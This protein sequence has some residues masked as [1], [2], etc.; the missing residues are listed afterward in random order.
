MRQPRPITTGLLRDWE[1]PRS[2]GSKESQGRVLV[3]GGNV[4]M[5]GGVLLAAEAAMRAGAGKLQVATVEQVAVPMAMQVPEAYVAGLPADADGNLAPE[6]AAEIVELAADCS[7]VLLGPGIMSPDSAV[8]LLS[9]VVPQLAVPVVVDALGMAYLTEHRDGVAHLDGRAILSPNLGE[10]A[11][12][13]G[14]D[15]DEV[16]DD[17]LTHARRLATDARAVVVTGAATTV[18][19]TPDDAACWQDE[20]GGEG[21]AVSGSGDVKAGVLLGLLGR[22]ATPEQAA[23]WGAFVHGRAGERLVAVHGRRGYLARELLVEIPR[24]LAELD[25]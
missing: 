25:G 2:G 3:V 9:E 4:R 22:G 5:P 24:T 1:L 20:S 17:P 11:V 19:C 23:A 7:A 14:L 16:S 12:T 8:A 18:I 6:S 10:L 21:M 15:Q 13:L